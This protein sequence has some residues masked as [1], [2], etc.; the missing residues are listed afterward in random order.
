ML[1]LPRGPLFN[2]IN[3]NTELAANKKIK[4]ILDIFIFYFMNSQQL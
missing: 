3:T 4:T 2:Q 1:K